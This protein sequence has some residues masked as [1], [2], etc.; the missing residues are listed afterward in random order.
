[1]SDWHPILSAVEGPTGTWRLVDPQGRQYGTVEIRRVMNGTDVRYRAVFRGEVIGW[2]T[3]L[4]IACERIHSAYVSTH[5]PN[6]GPIA[7]WGDRP[8]GGPAYR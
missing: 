1:M 8:A 5:G 6:G 4:R 7:D 3:S 2:S